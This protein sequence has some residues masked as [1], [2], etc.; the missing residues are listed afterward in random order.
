[1]EP[2]GRSSQFEKALLEL[3]A[4]ILAGTFEINMRLPE[5]ALAERLALSRTPLRQA[6][7]RLVEEGLL[8]KIPTGGC[9]VARL[10]ERDIIDAIEVRGVIE[11]TAARLAAER[12]A[13]PRQ[14]ALAETTLDAIDVALARPGGI[15]FAAYVHHNAAFHQILA[16]L[17]G[18]AVIE[19]EVDRVTRLPL[20]SPSAFLHGQ[21]LIPDF[22]QS[23]TRAQRQHR[24]I[25]SAI[26]A[27]EG[28]RAEA[29]AREHARLARENLAHVLRGGPRLAE[30][31]PGLALVTPS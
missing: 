23:L 22:Q 27:R 7:D 13:D 16:R 26:S 24:E 17:A 19:R 1:M 20:A 11:G 3:R 18:S 15:D 4:L 2:R 29:L 28:A 25:L 12:G 21:E 5:T 9:R 6:M 30:R 14:M 8:E 31:V 10:S